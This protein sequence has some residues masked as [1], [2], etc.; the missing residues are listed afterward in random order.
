MIYETTYKDRFAIT[1][2]GKE[3]TAVFLPKDGGKLAS[4]KTLTGIELLE[5]AKGDHYLPLTIDG[6]YIDAECSA[7]DDMFPTIDPCTMAKH[8][9]PDHGEVCRREHKWE[10]KNGILRLSCMVKSVNAEFTK[11]ITGDEAGISIRYIIRN[12]STKPLPYI[13]AGHMMFAGKPGAVVFSNAPEGSRKQV[14]FGNMPDTPEKIRPFT[15]NGES[16]KYYITEPF[17][18]LVCGIRYSNGATITVSFDENMVRWLGVWMNNGS[19]KGMYNLALEPCTAPYDSP[20]NA[21]NK[22][23]GSVIPGEGSIRFTMH[24]RYDTSTPN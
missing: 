20:K 7:F 1:V 5:Q 19:F 15:P 4:L 18:P 10:I 16:Y 17:T 24:L 21:E 8:D 9:Y 6:S 13:W 11:E 2:E 12:L 3:L 14:M 22:N 23:A